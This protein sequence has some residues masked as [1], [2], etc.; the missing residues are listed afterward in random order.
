MVDHLSEF[1]LRPMHRCADG[2]RRPVRTTSAES[3]GLSRQAMPCK[4]QAPP[5]P[6]QPAGARLQGDVRVW[7][8][9]VE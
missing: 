1:E 4:D 5:L 8:D 6:N 9:V 7:W 2:R 3:L